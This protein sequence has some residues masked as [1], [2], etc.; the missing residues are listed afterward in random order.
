MTV[1][2]TPVSSGTGGT[3]VMGTSTIVSPSSSGSGVVDF[4]GRGG[5]N[6]SACREAAVRVCGGL[7]SAWGRDFDKRLW[8]ECS[9]GCG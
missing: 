4:E 3:V 1:S 2:G 9:G 7:Y 8:F 5:K 6:R